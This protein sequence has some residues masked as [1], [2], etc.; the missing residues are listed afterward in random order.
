MKKKGLIIALSVVLVA[1]IAIFGTLLAMEQ[2]DKKKAEAERNEA[3]SQ[4]DKQDEKITVKIVS[5]DKTEKKIELSADA[6]SL[7]HALYKEGLVTE[8]EYKSGFY[9]V[10]DGVRADYTLDKAWWCVT[11]GGEMTNVGANDLEIVSG[12]CFEITYTPA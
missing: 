3:I 12:D 11:K 6:D 10:I 5:K 7:G 8:E 2:F 1:I 4:S 9:T